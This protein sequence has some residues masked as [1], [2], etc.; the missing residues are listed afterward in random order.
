ML[1]HVSMIADSQL[2]SLFTLTGKTAVITGAAMGIGK[3]TARLFANAGATV[4]VAD[5]KTEDAQRVADEL[6]SRGHHAAAISFDLAN[7]S[8]VL[9]LFEKIARDYGTV[10]IL[11]NNAGIYPKYTMESLGQAD[12]ARMQQINVWGCFL[13]MRAAAQRRSAHWESPS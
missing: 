10:D 3:A 5:C 13:C 7:E 4:I 9:R 8:S 12:W 2:T 6:T 1:A 11:V